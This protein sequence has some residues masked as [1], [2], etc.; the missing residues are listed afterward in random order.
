M[1]ENQN[2]QQLQKL[3]R[4]RR[5]IE[6]FLH[7]PL[8][9]E[10]WEDLVEERFIEELLNDDDLSCSWVAEKVRRRRQ[11]YG[12]RGV[13]R[14][15]GTHML[16]EQEVKE[17][18]GRLKALSILVAQEAAKDEEVQAIRTELLGGE[19]LSLDAVEE[20]IH[21]QAEADGRHTWWLTAIP[22]LQNSRL[23]NS[24]LDLAL[25]T[26][27]RHGLFERQKQITYTSNNFEVLLGAENFFFRFLAYSVP[28]SE[29]KKEIPTRYEGKLE[30][31]RQLSERLAQEYGWTEAQSTVFV[32]TGAVPEIT[33]VT[34]SFQ[35]RQLPALSRIV[36][37]IDPALS[38]KEVA[39]QYRMARQEAIAG[40][41][42]ELSEKH[43]Q[44]AIFAAKHSDNETWA[45][46]MAEWNKTHP[47]EWRYGEVA[48]FSHDCLQA[49]RRLLR[50]E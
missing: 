7:S 14:G 37:T 18:S 44:L 42:R 28:E 15:N 30:R 21:K 13:K 27:I 36:L 9:E 24:Q 23:E 43:M 19:L 4:I 22:F 35:S 40:R 2:I 45:E 6:I 16:T 5:E 12:Q 17:P 31:L 29:E 39:E 33:P 48:N 3:A 41:H 10:E 1:K 49:R 50:S 46:K 34:S 47:E 26:L 8:H 32:L 38:P 11:V 20:W 25:G